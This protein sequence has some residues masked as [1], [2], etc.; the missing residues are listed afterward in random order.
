[1]AA[2]RAA[3]SPAENLGPRSGQLREGSNGFHLS[4]HG[5]NSGTTLD[6]EKHSPKVMEMI[7]VGAAEEALETQS[8]RRC[9]I[10]CRCIEKVGKSVG[11]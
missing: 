4:A 9:A 2:A 5:S 7:R 6:H 10:L 11:S 3:F 1:M 8:L